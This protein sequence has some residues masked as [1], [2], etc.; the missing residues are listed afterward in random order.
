M[1][2]RCVCCGAII[3]EGSMVC[4]ACRQRAEKSDGAYNKE[5]WNTGKRGKNA[6]GRAGRTGGTCT[7]LEGAPQ[8]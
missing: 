7:T 5:E 6:R 1:E 4:Q 3:P 2:E 8:G